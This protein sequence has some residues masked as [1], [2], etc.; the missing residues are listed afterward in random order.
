MFVKRFD[1]TRVRAYFISRV[2]VGNT[3]VQRR[4]S[5]STLLHFCTPATTGEQVDAVT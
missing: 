2:G 3:I 4:K 1:W 5:W